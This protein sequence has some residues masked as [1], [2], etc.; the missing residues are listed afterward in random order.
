MSGYTCVVYINCLCSTTTVGF[1][2]V[3]QD[4]IDSTL[5]LMHILQA[6][7]LLFLFFSCGSCKSLNPFYHFLGDTVVTQKLNSRH[8]VLKYHLYFLLFFSSMYYTFLISLMK[9]ASYVI[10]KH[11]LHIQNNSLSRILTAH[12]LALDYAPYVFVRL[13]HHITLCT[14]LNTRPYLA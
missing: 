7:Y 14:L 2:V 3:A 5:L 10:Q 13:D 9:N 6:G 1:V 4:S 8:Q 12:C 11:Y